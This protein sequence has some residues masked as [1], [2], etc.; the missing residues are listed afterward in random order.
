MHTA[1]GHLSIC[2][3]FPKDPVRRARWIKAVR[4]KDW[5]PSS[6]SLLCSQH[7]SDDCFD[8]TSLCVV[9]LKDHAVPSIFPAY[10]A[11]LQRRLNKNVRIQENSLNLE[12]LEMVSVTIKDEAMDDLT[13]EDGAFRECM[14]PCAGTT[15]ST[16]ETVTRNTWFVKA[17][18][19]DSPSCKQFRDVA[20]ARC[21]KKRSYKSL[22]S[23]SGIR[24]DP[25]NTVWQ[26]WCR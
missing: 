1:V 2:Y 23:T 25:V 6:F 21:F 16:D 7:F 15:R 3:R 10:P 12:P 17:A 19:E 5:T 18:Y 13:W 8:K 11:H 22:Y 4:R 20:S 24:E 14:T 26:Q 9:R